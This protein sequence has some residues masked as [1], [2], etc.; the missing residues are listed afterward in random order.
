MSNR[1]NTHILKCLS[2]R[3]KLQKSN[4]HFNF[5]QN[6]GIHLPTVVT[7][8]VISKQMSHYIVLIVRDHWKVISNQIAWQTRWK[9]KTVNFY[10]IFKPITVLIYLTE[11]F[12]PFTNTVLSN[13]KQA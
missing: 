5:F 11:I 12:K 9:K 10:F 4:S 7:S 2:K 13:K 8:K 1:G 3:G 6:T